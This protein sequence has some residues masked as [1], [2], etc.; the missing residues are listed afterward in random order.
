MALPISEETL[1]KMIKENQIDKDFDYLENPQVMYFIIKENPS[2]TS[3]IDYETGERVVRLF[4]LDKN[5]II[6]KRKEIFL[7]LFNFIDNIPSEYINLIDSEDLYLNLA[8]QS[9]YSFKKLYLLN[10]NYKDVEKKLFKE[11]YEQ[12]YIYD[13]NYPIEYAKDSPIVLLNT[14]KQSSMNM[15]YIAFFSNEAVNDDVIKY[16]EENNL[17]KNFDTSYIYEKFPKLVFLK[18]KSDLDFIYKINP[19]LITDE[20]INYLRDNNIKMQNIIDYINKNNKFP[21]CLFSSKLMIY[22]LEESIDNIKWFQGNNVSDELIYYLIKNNYIYQK[23]HNKVLLNNDSIY[24]N[25]LEKGDY[26][27]LFVE[28][29]ELNKKQ[30]D[31][32]IE[33][34][35]A[36]QLSLP[37]IENE[38]L[39]QNEK[40]SNFIID[41]YKINNLYG[42]EN[43]F[44]ITSLGSSLNKLGKIFSSNE[45]KIIIREIIN[46]NYFIDMNSI[47]DN[48]SIEKFGEIYNELYRKENKF[49]SNFDFYYFIK[50]T[51]YMVNNLSLVKEI[52]EHEITDELI[53]NLALVINSNVSVNY[54]ELINYRNNKKENI[55][56]STMTSNDKIFKLLVNSDRDG[57]NNFINNIANNVNLTYLQLEFPIDFYEYQ[58]LES[59]ISI[60][61]ILEKTLNNNIS[62]DE[63]LRILYENFNINPIFDLKVMKENILKLYAKIYQK[64]SFS[65]DKYSYEK[66]G[67]NKVYDITGKDFLLFIHNPGFRIKSSISDE[68]E[69]V[70]S[71]KNYLCT[72]MV[73]ELSTFRLSDNR[74]EVYDYQNYTSLIA[75]GNKDINIDPTNAPLFKSDDSFI[76]PIDIAYFH[77]RSTN[78][79]NEF[80]FLRIDNKNNLL[81]P[82]IK[83]VSNK[84]DA[85][86]EQ[87]GDKQ[88]IVFDEEK[89]QEIM[90][91]R[92]EALCDEISSLNYKNLYK[93]IAMSCKFSLDN[94][95]ISSIVSRISEMNEKEQLVLNDALKRYQVKEKNSSKKM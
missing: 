93:L 40:F 80:D 35:K 42:L 38:Y 53:T 90:K 39:L 54:L 1:K 32:F 33:K 29:I 26:S 22:L 78:I 55:I 45:I 7:A 68:E 14:L 36:D 91:L 86:K 64:L 3:L 6:G 65:F 13:T 67:N 87:D 60:I 59:Y 25:F 89:H 44:L 37:N 10:H 74:Y 95:L 48:I 11:K 34:I 31:K 94:D 62:S 69:V 79:P 61:S 88:I 18:L 23:E 57:V 5:L 71:K 85:M 21:S 70:Q 81:T 75:F 12:E 72:T 66:I 8:N 63:V 52:D 92:F 20:M 19:N 41:Y 50:I 15:Y 30:I 46:N 82:K 49:N 58:F 83:I 51:G 77:S 24:Y 27:L 76:N 84:D 16:I 47:L 43:R 17:M 73:N 9:I 28:S 56:N 4:K 2:L